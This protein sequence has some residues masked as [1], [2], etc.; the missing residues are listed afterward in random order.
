MNSDSKPK[1]RLADV[2][3]LQLIIVIY[4]CSGIAAK[5]A[6]HYNFLSLGFIICYGIEIVI[7]GV[8]ALFWQQA[9]KKFDLSVAYANRG[10]A[11]FWSLVWSALIFSEKVT[12]KKYNRR[13]HYFCRSLYRKHWQKKRNQRRHCQ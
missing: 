6:S 12:V 5:F 8:Y 13:Y 11:I 9:I 7:L 1:I 10:V 3:I 4:T 2:I